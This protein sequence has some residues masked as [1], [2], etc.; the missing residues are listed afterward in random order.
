MKQYIPYEKLSKSAKRAFNAGRRG[1]WGT[2]NPVT[3]RSVTPRAYN[4]NREKQG[5]KKEAVC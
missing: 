2:L 5:A 1:S 4:R 3:R